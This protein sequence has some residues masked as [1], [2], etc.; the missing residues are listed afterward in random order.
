MQVKHHN[1]KQKSE[2][3]DKDVAIK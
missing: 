3:K 2:N 1:E